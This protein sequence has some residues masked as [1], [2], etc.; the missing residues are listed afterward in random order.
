MTDIDNRCERLQGEV[1]EALAQI[2]EETL[3]MAQL[4]REDDFFGLGGNSLLSMR[5]VDKIAE[6]FGIQLT[7]VALFQHPTIRAIAALIED[8]LSEREH[9]EL[10]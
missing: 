10:L 8:S 4:D 3:G 5:L 9:E 6:R 7:V 1:E 2:W